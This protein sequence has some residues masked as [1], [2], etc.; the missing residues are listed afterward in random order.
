MNNFFLRLLL[1]I[2]SRIKDTKLLSSLHLANLFNYK[3]FHFCHLEK[4]NY[5]KKG[6][7]R[8]NV[9]K[10]GGGAGGGVGLARRELQQGGGERR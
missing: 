5:P 8:G 4:G 3:C 1:K 9:R 10:G 2:R 6:A 7:S